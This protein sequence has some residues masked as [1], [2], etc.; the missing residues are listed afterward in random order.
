V[1][2]W[3]TSRPPPFV[4][5]HPIHKALGSTARSTWHSDPFYVPPPVLSNSFSSIPPSPPPPLGPLRPSPFQHPMCTTFQGGTA[6]PTPTR[7]VS[8]TFAHSFSSSSSSGLCSYTREDRSAS[9]LGMSSG[10]RHGQH[11]PITP[12]PGPAQP[13]YIVLTPQPGHCLS[14]QHWNQA[15]NP[16]PTRWEG[17]SAVPRSIS[18]GYFPGNGNGMLNPSTPWFNDNGH[19]RPFRVLTPG[20][21]LPYSTT[22]RLG[23]VVPSS[24]IPNHLPREHRTPEYEIYPNSAG[25]GVVSPSMSAAPS[26]VWSGRGGGSRPGIAS[27]WG[28][29][30]L[31]PT[32]DDRP[33]PEHRH[34]ASAACWGSNHSFFFFFSS[35]W[36]LPSRPPISKD[37]GHPLPVYFSPS[38]LLKATLTIK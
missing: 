23:V 14:Q 30:P 1:T 9:S 38:S 21:A 19:N 18:M 11:Q 7:I 25:G 16:V 20:S 17:S 2:A 6:N 24:A 34:F 27:K 31:T 15:P 3:R 22:T 4:T 13:Q 5:Y 26:L 32:T 33:L 12:A 36:T 10:S 28:S 29:A 35:F 8:P 37:P